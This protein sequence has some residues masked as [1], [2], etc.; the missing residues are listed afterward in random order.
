MQ[1][2]RLPC[3]DTRAIELPL[4]ACAASPGSAAAQESHLEQQAQRA[5]SD[6]S[7]TLLPSDVQLLR[8]SVMG[9]SRTLSSVQHH[10]PTNAAA[11]RAPAYP[12]HPI[13]S[14]APARPE[15][16][17]SDIA[18]DI[19]PAPAVNLQQQ[20]APAPARRVSRPL[21]ACLALPLDGARTPPL[22]A[23]DSAQQRTPRDA[24]SDESAD[25]VVRRLGEGAA[26]LRQLQAR[27]YT[28]DASSAATLSKVLD[29]LRHAQAQ[30]VDMTHFLI[31]VL[32][33]EAEACDT[34]ASSS[35]RTPRGAHGWAAAGKSKSALRLP[36]GLQSRGHSVQQA[37]PEMS[38]EWRLRVLS[39]YDG[40]PV[41]GLTGIEL[42]DADGNPCAPLPTRSIDF[43]LLNVSSAVL[44]SG[45]CDR[46]RLM[47]RP[48]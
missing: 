25:R 39:C 12:A 29:T 27:M 5:E 38:R 44:C 30:G 35:A 42:I 4:E 24:A 17:E 2:Q 43:H 31:N 22:Q 16:S 8:T 40:A 3:W 10:T 1:A 7:V 19:A 28:L 45:L 41:A 13:Q 37:A 9:L 47:Q 15:S 6:A 36:R 46:L 32:Q 34:P 11:D 18:E 21:S 14:I 20:A 23:R 48:T 33:G 26:I